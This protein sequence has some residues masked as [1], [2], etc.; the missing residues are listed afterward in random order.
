MTGPDR[1]LRLVPA[2]GPVDVGGPSRPALLAAVDAA[3]GVLTAHLARWAALPPRWRGVPAGP[4]TDPA[5]VARAGAQARELP[6]PV[7]LAEQADALREA[8]DVVRRQHVDTAEDLGPLWDT[9]AGPSADAVQRRVSALARSA[10]GLVGEL[11]DT[12]DVVDTAAGQVA[13][14][15]RDLAAGAAAVRPADPVGG[16][17]P[18]QVDAMLAAVR[19]DPGV[20]RPLRAWAADLEERLRLF[21]GAAARSRAAGREAGARVRERLAAAGPLGPPVSPPGGGPPPRSGPPSP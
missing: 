19:T 8:A 20:E 3:V 17:H 18:A 11:G 14:A 2:A 15:V 13:A 6:D 1:P 10:H 5:T 16:L 4:D 9:W 7:A 12:A 21:L